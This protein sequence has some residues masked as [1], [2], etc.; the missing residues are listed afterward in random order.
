MFSWIRHDVAEVC[1]LPSALLVT[2]ATE[3]EGI[4]VFTPFC[5]SVC[6]CTGYLKKLCTDLDETW[7]T[8]WVCDKEELI[9]FW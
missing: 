2:S 6:L 9:R 5:L 3:V 8:F 7:W 4:Y 1:A